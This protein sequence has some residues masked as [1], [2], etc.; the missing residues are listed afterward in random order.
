MR[1]KGIMEVGTTISTEPISGVVLVADDDPTLRFI[2]RQMLVQDGHEVVLAEDGHEACR[3]FDM[4]AP[5]LLLMD[6]QMPVLNGFQACAQLRRRRD[7]A[8]TPIIMITSCDDPESV[9]RAF[10]SGATDFQA[11]PLNWRI[12]RQRVRYMLTAQR[13]ASEL[14]RLTRDD[15][16][17]ES[18]QPRSA[19]KS[20]DRTRRLSKPLSAR[21]ERKIT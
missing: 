13:A 4:R 8:Q 19:T 15:N 11:K 3:L 12:V 2:A 9:E 7:G 16:F 1:L 18:T 10:D 6:V 17:T 5:D 20:S 21:T 14:R